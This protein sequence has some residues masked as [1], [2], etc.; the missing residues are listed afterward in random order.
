MSMMGGGLLPLGL[1]PGTVASVSSGN[2]VAPET[3]RARFEAEL[4]INTASAS[5]P[6]INNTVDD[7]TFLP[8]LEQQ[9]ILANLQQRFMEDVI[10]TNIGSV[11]ISMNPYR[12]IPDLYDLDMRIRYTNSRINTLPPHIFSIAD[13]AYTG[14]VETG[15]NQSIV[16]SGESGAGKTEA[17]KLCIQFIVSRS[18]TSPV[19]QNMIVLS[20]PLL[21]AFGNATTVRNDNSSRF[22]KY[23]EIFLT[24]REEIVGGRIAHYLLEKSRICFHSPNERGYHIFYQLCAGADPVLR[25]ELSLRPAGYY[26]YLNVGSYPINEAN[27]AAAFDTTSRSLQQ[28]CEYRARLDPKF[29]QANE[30]GNFAKQIWRIIAGILHLG[31]VNFSESRQAEGCTIDNVEELSAAASLLGFATDDLVEILTIRRNLIRNESFRTPLTGTQ[32]RAARDF[33][34]KEIY[35]ALFAYIIDFVNQTIAPDKRYNN[36]P[37]IGILDIFGFENFPF[38]TYEQ[39]AINLANEKFLSW[40]N[41]QFFA[42]EEL[43]YSR[44]NITCAKFPWEDNRLCMELLEGR[45]PAGITSVL[46]DESKLASATDATFYS[47]VA[48]LQHPKLAINP[49]TPGQFSV[50][51]Y[52]G[53][54]TYHTA[55]WLSKNANEELFGF[56]E[57]L[58][59][60]EHPIIKA[61]APACPREKKTL[62]SGFVADLNNLLQLL[63][64]THG[65]YIRAL[66]PN[67]TKK[68]GR[69]DAGLLGM[70][71]RNTGLLETIR[72]RQHGYPIRFFFSEFY[73]R[74]R[75]LQ[76]PPAP[77]LI[78]RYQSGTR[79]DQT[80][81]K[82]HVRNLLEDL[83][84]AA[85][86]TNVLQLGRT[87][88]FM[89]DS[90]LGELED[91]R[92]IKREDSAA[93]IQ[94][95]WRMHLQKKELQK[96]RQAAI[97]IQRWFRG[98]RVRRDFLAKRHAVVRLQARFRGKKA[99]THFLA[100][101]EQ[102]QQANPAA[103]GAFKAGLE[104][105]AVTIRG[106]AIAARGAGAAATTPWG[107][108]EAMSSALAESPMQL[109]KLPAI[110]AP[111][112]ASHVA[113][114]DFNGV[115][116]GDLQLKKGDHIHVVSQTT[117]WWT[118]RTT[119]GTTGTFPGNYVEPLDKTSAGVDL[120]TSASSSSIITPFSRSQTSSVLTPFSRMRQ[121]SA[122]ISDSQ[123][124]APNADSSA[125]SSGGKLMRT[126]SVIASSAIS[127]PNAFGRLLPTAG[128][129]K[130]LSRTTS[131]MVPQITR[132]TNAFGRA[133]TRTKSI[134]GLRQDGG[135]PQVLDLAQIKS[136]QNIAVLSNPTT[137]VELQSMVSHLETKKKTGVEQLFAGAAS[138]APTPSLSLPGLNLDLSAVKKPEGA[139]DNKAT[140][141]LPDPPAHGRRFTQSMM[142]FIPQSAEVEETF[143]AVPIL[144][145]TESIMF[146]WLDYT[147]E[148]FQRQTRKVN[149]KNTLVPWN[150]IV[151]YQAEELEDSLHP[152]TEKQRKRS[153]ELQMKDEISQAA[154]T[155]FGFGSM[156]AE[157]DSFLMET[158]GV[159]PSEEDYKK[160]KAELKQNQQ[161]ILEAKLKMKEREFHEVDAEVNK[162]LK[163]KHE[164]K[165]LKMAVNSFGTILLYQ[166][167]EE[168]PNAEKLNQA[169]LAKVQRTRL[170]RAIKAVQFLQLNGLKFPQLRDEIYCQ[171]VKQTRNCP[172][173]RL[174]ERAWHLLAVITGLFAPSTTFVPYLVGYLHLAMKDW[175]DYRKKAAAWCLHRLERTFA[176]GDR[177]SPMGPTELD[178]TLRFEDFTVPVELPDG[179]TKEIPI[180][181][182]TTY[183]EVFQQVCRKVRVQDARGWAIFEVFDKLERSLL[184][185][186]FIAD[187]FAKLQTYE[188]HIATQELAEQ[189][190]E[191]SR[192]FKFVFKKKLHI[193]PHFPSLDD[194]ENRLMYFQSASDFIQGKIPCND[195]QALLLGALL[196]QAEGDYTP[197]VK[198]QEELDEEARRQE[199]I[200]SGIFDAELQS[201]P[202][203]I[204]L[205]S[206]L[207]STVIHSSEAKDE[208][209][210][211]TEL[212]E[213]WKTIKGMTVERAHELFLIAVKRL[214][215]FGATVFHVSQK[216]SWEMPA[217][218]DL[219]VSIDGLFFVDPVDG[220]SIIKQL[221]LA[222]ISR[223][224]PDPKGVTIFF[225]PTAKAL[226][227]F[228]KKIALFT[229]E[230]IEVASV[231]RQYIELLKIES[232]WCRATREYFG[233]ENTGL[234]SFSVGD[235]IQ[236]RAR[237]T[238]GFWLGS[239]D[240]QTGLFPADCVEVIIT[241][242]SEDVP[243]SGRKPLTSRAASSSSDAA[244]SSSR[245]EAPALA[246][247]QPTAE[248]KAAQLNANN[249]ALTITRDR[250]VSTKI[251]RI[252]TTKFT[253][254]TFA[255]TSMFRTMRTM[256]TGT[257]RTGKG[258]KEY[259]IQDR[260]QWQKD[261]LTDSL[262]L[263]KSE[264]FNQK[265]ESLFLLVQKWMGDAPLKKSETREKCLQELIQTGLDHRPLRDEIFCQIVK[266]S[267]ENPSDESTRRGWH[268]LILTASC[269]L[270]SDAFARYLLGH[271]QDH[272]E[273]KE[274]PLAHLAL[275][276]DECHE[277]IART[278]K[279]GARKFAPSKIEIT[280]V[281][282][283]QPM[284]LRLN[285]VDGSAK[286]VLLD[287]AC[288]VDEILDELFTKLDLPKTSATREIYSVLVGCPELFFEIGL[289]PTENL[290][291][292]LRW[293]EL[294]DMPK[295]IQEP[296]WNFTFK[297]RL[298]FFPDRIDLQRLTPIELHFM[299]WQTLTN[300]LESR[301]PTTSEEAAEMAAIHIQVQFGEHE[302]LFT[303]ETMAKYIPKRLQHLKEFDDWQFALL[304]HCAKN[305]GKPNR[306]LQIRYLE[307]ARAWPCWGASSFSCRRDEKPHDVVLYLY[308]TG[309]HISVPGRRKPLVTWSYPK[310]ASWVATEKDFVFR[311]GGI[312]EAGQLVKLYTRQAEEIKRTLVAYVDNLV[313]DLSQKK[314]QD[315]VQR[316]RA[317]T[318]TASG[319]RLLKN[320]SSRIAAAS[321][322]PPP[323][324][325]AALP[326]PLHK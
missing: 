195:S 93:L 173:E 255:T 321:S 217:R 273:L 324:P 115:R 38:N 116:R 99:R 67:G 224:H 284:Y 229:Q 117:A 239:L 233:G 7:M 90:L 304:P 50:S 165:M 226:S 95:T 88:V 292:R 289:L 15:K 302:G 91:A 214:P 70:Q 21:E 111:F 61:I 43:E 222:A 293:I 282:N 203:E 193:D 163:E 264:E 2:L 175:R 268:L 199:Q 66:K 76:S 152:F 39:F 167:M 84:E 274:G 89:K 132:P 183:L 127:R 129:G 25:E 10:Y 73:E 194:I 296:T 181:S 315:M 230:S 188:T 251:K 244:T 322:A 269:F 92:D 53:N 3:Q 162:E 317:R 13:A 34:A 126:T 157:W 256:R 208:K 267:T 325:L 54:V 231:I 75:I 105:E 262:T 249:N 170:M 310:I 17:A 218:I 219:A 72:I 174:E 297:R 23:I 130:E 309:M 57:L 60:S 243:L 220:F 176:N 24:P 180:D 223:T 147:R 228:D 136:E 213:L 323:P 316:T 285:L 201:V 154:G 164:A 131:T 207:P 74:F 300:V 52:A 266:Q 252:D 204:E 313:A 118:G 238:D 82:Q 245:G 212:I 81:Y 166:L 79:I 172:K 197:H 135:E 206:Y 240:E 248:E 137:P 71:L 186:D 87:K 144:D 261:P 184:E 138:A 134:M 294:Y 125:S 259:N 122:A 104:K 191:V 69:I 187:E 318:S 277:R 279:R 22:G 107:R 33:V 260:I 78:S 305:R 32:A 237:R 140:A 311:T 227:G 139:A 20:G 58:Q 142:N 100:Q 283:G 314:K 30:G 36:C 320:K 232:E 270:P 114:F 68:P 80:A 236:I 169:Q 290:A 254:R 83:V 133:P 37:S 41:E 45:K 177:T 200:R 112:K 271:V 281:A 216:S 96:M 56:H 225:D 312:G 106:S 14:L 31:N 42:N 145:D 128:G 196:A 275:L 49:R 258:K 97:K 265:A 257:F 189:K 234:L 241:D 98:T 148:H 48:M 109:D 26:N 160:A 94:A 178:A 286:T 1:K 16:I 161:T 246:R 5:V 253:M 307:L 28:I 209:A 62:M 185:K 295:E 12:D 40:F 190:E 153:A 55:G 29:A 64:K 278:I 108:I 210:W 276:A 235:M 120:T 149:F 102:R 250:F 27:D 103:Y 35:T 141:I 143:E 215:L 159:L 101:Q 46:E 8:K 150:T 151:S 280:S 308:S 113:L 247:E 263:T 146:Q 182:S 299:F 86:D 319:V 211:E 47:H 11:L 19:L 124:A 303:P 4:G 63:T 288:I 272:K 44:E 192:G 123:P 301:H 9:T 291:D 110:P 121:A 326:P 155:S 242:L 202:L 65:H 198:T 298:F 18:Q 205:A 306:E 287:A 51:H 6:E 171:I 179:T 221:P 168:I 158:G 77:G 85:N 59:K 156:M 119:D